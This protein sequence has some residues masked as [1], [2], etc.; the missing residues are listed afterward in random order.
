MRLSELGQRLPCRAP[1]AT[2]CVG[3]ATISWLRGQDDEAYEGFQEALEHHRGLPMPLA[4]AETLLAFGRF[5]RRSGRSSE[6]RALLGRA[7]QLVEPIGARRIGRL[8]EHEL[9]LAGGRRRHAGRSDELTPQER[10]IAGLAAK[11]LTSP[12]IARELFISAK[13]VDHHLSH[14]Y[15][16]LGITSRRELMRSWPS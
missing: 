10:R 16:K 3:L 15:A 13:T 1:R 11:G 6:A 9:A 4:E 14:I 5:C 8:V 2:A 7:L 12:A